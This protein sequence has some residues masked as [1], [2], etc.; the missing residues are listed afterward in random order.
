M[1]L[2]SLT[3]G[4]PALYKCMSTTRSIWLRVFSAHLYV[5]GCVC[6]SPMLFPAL[7]T[8]WPGLCDFPA[9]G[10]QGPLGHSVWANSRSQEARALGHRAQRLNPEWVSVL[11]SG[12]W[13]W[14]CSLCGCWLVLGLSLF[15]KWLILWS[16]LDSF[17]RH[18]SVD[19]DATGWYK[20]IYF[21]NLFHGGSN[22]DE[23]MS[24]P[25]TGALCCLE[26]KK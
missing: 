6:S 21:F 12:S 2:H 24:L 25:S 16:Y 17:G 22:S 7:L 23:E 8:A 1:V 10:G 4:Q 5:C 19:W 14:G 15:Q 20:T 9:L 13:P 3:W 18:P 26:R 11:G